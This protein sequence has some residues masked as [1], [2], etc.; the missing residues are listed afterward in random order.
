M[1]PKSDEASP[2]YLEGY[3]ELAEYIASDADLSMYKRFTSL[4]A[5]NILYLQAEIQVLDDDLRRLDRLD[6]EDI[7]KFDSSGMDIIQAA[8]DWQTFDRKARAGDD[9]QAKKM[10]LVKKIRR[11]IKEYRISP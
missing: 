7:K 5:R 11:A 4:S 9:R 10:A 2:E 6:H 8:K 1:V 3:A